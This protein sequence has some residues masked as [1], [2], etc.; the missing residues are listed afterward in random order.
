M[1]QS[2]I[3]RENRSTAPSL[4]GSME[5]KETSL[6]GNFALASATIRFCSSI[7]TS[8]GRTYPVSCAKTHDTG[9]VRPIDV[10]IEEQN[11]MVAEASAK[12]PDRLVSFFSIDPRREGAV[13]LFSR[14]IE[15]WGMKGLKL[16]PASGFYPYEEFCYP[17]YEKC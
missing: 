7:C 13:D 16:H 14:A 8:I 9:Y 5:K 4:L 2:S 3:T 15:D 10:Q 6:S 11:R 17:L 1:P 12:F